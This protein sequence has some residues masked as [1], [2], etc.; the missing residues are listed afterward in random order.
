MFSILEF[1]DS[2][3]SISKLGPPDGVLEP[4]RLE[5][6]SIDSLTGEG[7]DSGVTAAALDFS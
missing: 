7:S 1:F 3:E 6:E 4:V 5:G 2:G